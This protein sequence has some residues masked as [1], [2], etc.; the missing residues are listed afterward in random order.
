MAE[1]HPEEKQYYV[2]GSELIQYC[3]FRNTRRPANPN[4]TLPTIKES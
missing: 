2:S 1:G 3:G 4:V